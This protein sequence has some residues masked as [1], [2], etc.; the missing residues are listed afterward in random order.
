MQDRIPTPGQEGRVLITPENGSPAY[1]AKVEM[2]DNP[3]QAGTPF[4]KATLWKDATAALFGLGVDSVPDDGFAYLGK[5]AQHWWRRRTSAKKI[6][7]AT[8][9]TPSSTLSIASASYSTTKTV[10]YDSTY[11]ISQENGTISFPN[12]KSAT[13]F[14]ATASS[15]ANQFNSII[16]TNYFNSSPFFARLIKT[17]SASDLTEDRGLWKLATSAFVLISTEITDVPA[18]DWQYVQS[19][20]RSSYPDSGE[21]DGYEYEYLGIPFD[22]AVGAPKIET[23]SYVGTGTYGQS[24][25]NTLTFNFTPKLVLIARVSG[26]SSPDYWPTFS[27]GIFPVYAL[28]E[29][30]SD[31]G[32]GYIR[33]NANDLGTD[34]YSFA[35]ISGNSLIWYSNGGLKQLNENSAT[36]IYLA[37]G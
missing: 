5:Y 28:T 23:G 19:S 22:N 34:N 7:S 14:E 13:I 6:Y 1:Y 25:P 30:Y 8:E 3:S 24:S 20:D 11:N 10:T 21:Q 12:P 4:N 32:S 29:N 2:A 36:Y 16:G 37:I 27:F 33:M 31:A 18:G 15:A 9:K 26:G 35:K 17:I